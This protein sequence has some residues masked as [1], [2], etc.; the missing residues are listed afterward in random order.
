MGR[1]GPQPKAP[2]I[3]QAQGFPSRRRR[4][5]RTQIEA[6][7]E[8]DATCNTNGQDSR[9]VPEPPAWLTNKRAREIWREKFADPSTR[10]WFKNSDHAFIARYCQ[11]RAEY[12]RFVKRRPTATYET[13]GASG[14][15]IRKN[16]EYVMMQ[17]LHRDLRAEEQLLAGNPVARVDMAKRTIGQGKNN[18][19]GG[20]TPDKQAAGQ[21]ASGPLGALKAAA[22]QRPN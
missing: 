10:I 5:T 15:I 20:A 12:E 18:P 4:Q 6:K 3:E 7:K 22:T 1:R 19:P 11:R 9:N 21:P 8:P 14:R 2:E 13:F 17:D 16:P